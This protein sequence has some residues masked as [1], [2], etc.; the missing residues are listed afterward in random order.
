MFIHAELLI[1]L[2]SP[3]LAQVGA[4]T[5]QNSEADCRITTTDTP[6]F[7]QR[8]TT[9]Q[10]IG[11]ILKGNQ[12]FLREPP[13]RGLQL[14]VVF[15]PESGKL[16]YIQTKVLDYCHSN[17]STNNQGQKIS[18]DCRRVKG[19]VDIEY[20]IYPRPDKNYRPIAKVRGGQILIL[21]L[22]QNRSVNT[23]RNKDIDWVAIDLYR[24]P[25]SRQNAFSKGE[26]G[27]IENQD[28]ISYCSRPKV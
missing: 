26:I 19:A 14:I 9:S 21:R 27:W 22:N 8:I 25:T 28:N 13:K 2:H 15:D 23:V 11:T 6:L 4:I 1:F 3:S 7:I 10:Q 17:A 20:D 16:G 18:T 12:V 24:T 5:K